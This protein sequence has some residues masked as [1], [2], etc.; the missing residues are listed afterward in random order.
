MHHAKHCSQSSTCWPRAVIHMQRTEFTLARV[1]T[2][3]NL[4]HTQCQSMFDKLN[5]F[6]RITPT[7][8][9]RALRSR[10]FALEF[11]ID[12]FLSSLVRNGRYIYSNKYIYIYIYIYIP[13]N[14][15]IRASSETKFSIHN[16]RPRYVRLASAHQRVWLASETS[17]RLGGLASLPIF[18]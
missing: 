8:V 13:T 12:Y 18:F 4:Y 2:I 17:T 1:L 14:N 9:A 7:Q 3:N 5:S 10:Y 6:V 15:Q 16:A 11:F